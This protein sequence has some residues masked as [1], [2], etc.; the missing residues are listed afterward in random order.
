MWNG[1][2]LHWIVVEFI[3]Q[4]VVIGVESDGMELESP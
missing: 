2:E 1:V 3:T 4:P